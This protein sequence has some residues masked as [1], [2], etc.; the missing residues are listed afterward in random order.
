[1]RISKSRYHCI[2]VWQKGGLIP[3][4]WGGHLKWGPSTQ[5]VFFMREEDAAHEARQIRDLPPEGPGIPAV[6]DVARFNKK[7]GLSVTPQPGL[8]R[9]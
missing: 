6:V 4:F 2:V 7:H 9:H 3:W 1:M 5:A 8:V